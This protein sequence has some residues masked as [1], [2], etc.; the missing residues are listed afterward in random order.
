MNLY[1]EELLQ[2]TFSD[3]VSKNAYLAACKWLAKKVYSKPFAKYVTVKIEKAENDKKSKIT[4]FVVKLFLCI[5]YD[6]IRKNNC[7]HCTDLHTIFYQLEKIDCDTCKM[8]AF[9]KRLSGASGK[10]KDF[11]IGQLEDE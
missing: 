1:C 8:H 2:K 11:L 5:N 10:L 7:K 4:T 9:D 3:T 6:E